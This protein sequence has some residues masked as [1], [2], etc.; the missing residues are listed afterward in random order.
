M[1]CFGNPYKNMMELAAISNECIKFKAVCVDCGKDAYISH[2][3]I[4]DQ[5]GEV[6]GSKD[7][8]VALCEKHHIIRTANKT[9]TKKVI[10][11]G[12]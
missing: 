9:K 6:V 10:T 2:I 3:L 5:S 11:K 7:I 1:N 4:D 8:Y 12:E